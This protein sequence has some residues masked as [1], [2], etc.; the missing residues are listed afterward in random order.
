MVRPPWGV[1]RHCFFGIHWTFSVATQPL[2]YTVR[3]HHRS[4]SIRI[5]VRHDG[6][7]HV[8]APRRVSQRAIDAFVQRKNDWI[9]S[10]QTKFSAMPRLA[11]G[12]G[13]REE[14]QEKRDE[15]LSLVAERVAYFNVFYGFQVGRL[16]V[17]NQRT[18]WGSCNRS[19]DLCF[20]YRIVFLPRELQDY[21]IV[22]ELCH[23]GQFNHSPKFWEL[24]AKTVP[25]YTVARRTL[26]TLPL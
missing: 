25:G 23:I 6:T 7:V 17:R 24:V 3:R 16:S 13:S 9:V 8:T 20:N 1:L 26:R 14:Y 12:L 4:R 5:F 15:A 22:H 21:L 11:A 19:G 10:V 2:A 18:R